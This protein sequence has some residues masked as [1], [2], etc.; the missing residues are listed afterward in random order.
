MKECEHIYIRDKIE[1]EEA[2]FEYFAGLDKLLD[3]NL[4]YDE[5]F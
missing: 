3:S 1:C 5:W 4:L 2:S